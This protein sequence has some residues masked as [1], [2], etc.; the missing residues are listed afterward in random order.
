LSVS[1][2]QL[3]QVLK[4]SGD[5]PLAESPK[6]TQQCDDC[7]DSRPKEPA[8]HGRWQVSS[9]AMPAVRTLKPMDLVFRDKRLNRR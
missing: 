6:T 2:F 8:W 7:H 9:T 5:H 1:Y 4:Y 3:L